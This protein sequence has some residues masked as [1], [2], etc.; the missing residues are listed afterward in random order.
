[1]TRAKLMKAIERVVERR[2]GEMYKQMIASR[3]PREVEKLWKDRARL[4]RLCKALT[5]NAPR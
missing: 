2:L 4:R 5:G 1:M 3:D